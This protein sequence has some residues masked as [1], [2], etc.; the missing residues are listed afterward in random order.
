MR[1]AML[2]QML[3]CALLYLY[4]VLDKKNIGFTLWFVIFAVTVLLISIIRDEAFIKILTEGA[5]AYQY[6]TMDET[7]RNVIGMLVGI[8]AVFFFHFTMTKNRLFVIPTVVASFVGLTTGSRK[9]LFAA[10]V[11]ILLYSFFHLQNQKEKKKKRTGIILLVLLIL[12][13]LIYLCYTN[14]TLYNV[15][16]YRIEGLLGTWFGGESMEA[17]AVDRAEMMEKAMEMFWEKPIFGWGIEGFA[18]NSSF[19]TYSH[20]NF[21]EVLAN[22]GIVGFLVF[23]VYKAV[24]LYHQYRLLRSSENQEEL[25]L[26]IFLTVW[27]ILLLML[28]Y[29]AVSMNSFT[30]NMAFAVAA[31]WQFQCKKKMNTRGARL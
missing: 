10:L 19:G 6:Y 25:S 4:C 20:N 31:A 1:D 22:F 2:Y 26:N 7:N 13:V 15:I 5:D 28:D 16:G 27:L 24:I 9:A 17:S 8:G 23:Y 14:E 21:T 18:L 11:G 12:F 30:N 3:Y 29:G